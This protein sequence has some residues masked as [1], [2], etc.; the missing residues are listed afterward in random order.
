VVATTITKNQERS[1]RDKEKVRIRKSRYIK[2]DETYYYI[3]KF[4]VVFSLCG[5][6]EIILYFSESF[7]ETACYELRFFELDKSI[8]LVLE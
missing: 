7:L 3:K 8:T 6:L 4:N 1:K 5:V 2:S